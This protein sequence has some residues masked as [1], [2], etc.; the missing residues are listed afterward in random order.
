MNA[1]YQ[2]FASN[3][4]F[5]SLVLNTTQNLIFVKNIKGQFLF[6]N[7]A[8][9]DLFGMEQEELIR[10]YNDEIHHNK[11][12]TDLYNKI[13]YEV[14]T[15]RRSIEITESF[16]MKNGETRWFQTLKQ[17]MEMA[18]GE[19][20]VL[21]VSMDVTERKAAFSLLENSKKT[22]EKILDSLPINIFA[23]DMD[24]RFIFFNKRCAVTTGVKKEDAVG[25]NDF[26]IF[27]ED[28]A[29]RLV[30]NDRE[31][32]IRNEP[33]FMEETIVV[34]GE[35]K[36]LYAGKVPIDIGNN[37]RILL[38]FS[39][40]ITDRKETEERLRV[41]NESLAEL[42]EE[43]IAESRQKDAIMAHQNRLATMGEM[44]A[45]IAHQ[46]KQP[47]NAVGLMIQ[48]LKMA[49]S[50]G[51]DDKGFIEGIIEDCMCQIKYMSD[52]IEDFRN[53]FLPEQKKSFFDI[54]DAVSKAVSFLGG[55]FKRSDIQ[56]VVEKSDSVT[57][58]GYENEFLQVILNILSNSKDAIIENRIEKPYIKISIKNDD[59]YVVIT[60]EDN[61][62]GI[63][64]NIIGRIFEPYFTTKESSNGTG[65]GL[66]MSKMI[67]EEQM[68]G[69]LTIDS[70]GQNTTATIKLKSA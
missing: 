60:I 36:Y 24:G 9:A 65:I 29:R 53:F 28:V 2:E 8:V 14:I 41:I 64:N 11:D 46:W 19:V 47:L 30:A 54:G 20:V 21:A 25:K 18:D 7:K 5:L 66:Y 43:Q 42:I 48:E 40:D 17:P 22:T 61:G 57:A 15:N 12:E 23:K 1:F 6:A 55:S 44:I 68:N 3:K 16:T 49:C 31:A 27:G 51:A 59:E 38:G 63:S 4:N 26:D 58:C 70:C 35:K 37:K 67:I 62:G 10:K 56:V 13:D 39:M 69:L 45:N 52:T 33:T 50:L 32:I 34:N